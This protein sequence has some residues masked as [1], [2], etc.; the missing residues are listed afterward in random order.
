LIGE[1]GEE[2]GSAGL[3]VGCG[4]IALA[5]QHG[6]EGRVGGEVGAGLADR[7][8]GVDP[9]WWTRVSVIQAASAE[10]V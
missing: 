10:A 9:V 3:F 5:E 2:L 4:V 1:F 8:D 7:L 6:L